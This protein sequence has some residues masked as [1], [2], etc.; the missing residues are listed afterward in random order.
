MKEEIIVLRLL[1]YSVLCFIF[2]FIQG[3]KGCG[4]DDN[5]KE[6]AVKPTFEYDVQKK[7]EE[8][9]AK[10]EEPE[11]DVPEEDDLVWEDDSDQSNDIDKSTQ[12]QSKEQEKE[13]TEETQ[14]V[15]GQSTLPSKEPTV[16]PAT[17]PTTSQT[18]ET[19]DSVSEPVSESS[20]EVTRVPEEQDVTKGRRETVV[21]SKEPVEKNKELSSRPTKGAE[22]KPSFSDNGRFVVQVASLKDKR[23]AVNLVGKLKSQGYPVYVDLH[24]TGK[25]AF[26]RVRIGNFNSQSAAEEFRQ[27][28]LLVQGYNTSWVDR[29]K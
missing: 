1:I 6:T 23:N 19:I 10:K 17:E 12:G 14:E 18:E 27:K 15:S 22:Y 20:E 13:Q 5:N 24:E 21:A 29:R 28:I 11:L 9:E 4:D 16:E 8:A 26:Y 25:E 7:E 3:C 2:L